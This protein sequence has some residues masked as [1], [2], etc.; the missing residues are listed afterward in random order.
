MDATGYSFGQNLYFGNHWLKAKL[1]RADNSVDGNDSFFFNFDKID[2]NLLVTRD[3]R[4][5]RAIDY[6]EYK[7]VVFYFND[8]AVLFKHLDF[9]NDKDLFQIM[10]NGKEKYSL[11][12][13]VRTK[14]V[15]P[16]YGAGTYSPKA[17]PLDRYQDVIFYYVF[18]PNKD[19]KKLTL[20]KKSGVERMFRLDPDAPRVN[21]YFQVNDKK[22]LKEEDL[23][24]LIS[25]LNK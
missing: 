1:L 21:D 10:I 9:I 6:R 5:I 25:Y 2:R 4:D 24:Q 18:F 12:K 17:S 8:T 14:I 13:V 20:L 19:Y 15:K 23:V 16:F 7:A 11:C 22:D 3:L